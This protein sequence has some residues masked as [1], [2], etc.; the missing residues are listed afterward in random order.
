M[1]VLSIVP[2]RPVGMSSATAAA[3]PVPRLWGRY[4][5]LD[6]F[7]A[8]ARHRLPRAIYGYASGG[9]ADGGAVR[10]NRAA[11]GRWHFV[12][13][14]LRDVASRTPARTLFGHRYDVPFGIAPMGAAAVAAFDADMRMARAARA[15]NLPFVLSANSITPMEAVAAVN[16]GIW[17]AA[18]LPPAPVHIDGML[19]RV[20][21]AGIRV[22]VVTVDVPAGSNR[23]AERRNGYTMPLRP[24]ARLVADGLAHPRW[25]LGTAAR[26]LARQG[27]PV[28]SNIRPRGGP[29]LFSRQVSF[30]G[31]DGA[32]T[33]DHVRQIRRSWQ[34]TLVLKGVLSPADARLARQHGADGIVVSNHGGRQLDGVA[35][36]MDML[37]AVRDASG[38]MAVL[39]DSGFRRGGDIL[40]ALALG[41][42]FVLIGRPFLYAAAL[43]GEAGVRHAAGLLRREVDLD[44]AQLGLATLADIGPACLIPAFR[45]TDA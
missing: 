3:A 41:A 15:A 13:R 18:Y 24:N 38:D 36:P 6:D 32:F 19:A 10:D 9:A 28:I 26:T 11:F 35:S 45:K 34:G 5:N 25:L 44:M 29:G 8:A 17:F 7:E 43:A 30:I 42:D 12:T 20:A 16:P 31:G 23:E 37:G 4:L 1:T 14:I 2:T 39:V 27:V 21:A 40:K 33:W 22:L